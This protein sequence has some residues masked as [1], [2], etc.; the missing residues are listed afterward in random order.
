MKFC[1]LLSKKMWRLCHYFY[2]FYCHKSRCCF[3]LFFVIYENPFF[4]FVNLSLNIILI[5][6]FRWSQKILRKRF[7]CWRHHPQARTTSRKHSGTSTNTRAR[8]PALGMQ[9]HPKGL[10]L[11]WS[12]WLCVVGMFSVAKK[13]EC[14]EHTGGWRHAKKNLREIFWDHLNELISIVLQKFLS[15]SFFKNN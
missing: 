14:A 12:F 7:I 8:R 5:S 1:W 6:S 13:F 11:R 4:C 10:S 9:A 2:W 3:Y 15:F